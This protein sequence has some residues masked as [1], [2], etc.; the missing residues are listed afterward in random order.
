MKTDGTELTRFSQANAVRIFLEGDWIYWSDGENN[1][2]ESSKSEDIHRTRTDG[3]EEQTLKTG[4]ITTLTAG[5]GAIFYGE[6]P[7]QSATIQVSQM[8]LDG[9]SVQSILTGIRIRCCGV[10]QNRLYYHGGA[11]H[12][13]LRRVNL[14]GSGSMNILP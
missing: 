4:S 2:P 10:Y 7:S 13:A 8:N 11:N 6:D 5:G 1:S 9:S 14:D 12:Q 3:S